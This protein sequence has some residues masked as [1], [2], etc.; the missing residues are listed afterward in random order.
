MDI[1]DLCIALILLVPPCNHPV[2]FFPPF[3]EP[4]PAPIRI[5]EAAS[6]AGGAKQAALGKGQQAA[7]A[8][9]RAPQNGV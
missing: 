7:A 5:D 9:D 8:R 2:A 6:G 1:D 3:F 4:L